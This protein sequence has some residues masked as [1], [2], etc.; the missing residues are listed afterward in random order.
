[1]STQTDVEMNGNGAEEDDTCSGREHVSDLPPNQ[2]ERTGQEE[3]KEVQSR[4]NV[5]L[6]LEQET[7]VQ[8]TIHPSTPVVVSP[9][10]KVSN[11]VQDTNSSDCIQVSKNKE[12]TRQTGSNLS[13]Y[14][15]PFGIASTTSRRRRKTMGETG[16]VE[17]VREI[18]RIYGDNSRR[19]GNSRRQSIRGG[20]GRQNDE[21][22]SVTSRF[23]DAEKDDEAVRSKRQ[24]QQRKVEQKRLNVK[25][26]LADTQRQQDS[27]SSECIDV[28]D[29][30]EPASQPT[31]FDRIRTDKVTNS[32]MQQYL[33]DVVKRCGDD[34]A[35]HE[36]K[37]NAKHQ[38]SRRFRGDNHMKSAMAR[39]ISPSKGGR[40]SNRDRDG[41]LR[42]QNRAYGKRDRDRGRRGVAFCDSDPLDQA[43]SEQEADRT[44]HST[45]S[46]RETVVE[47]VR[48]SQ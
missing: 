27:A 24:K 38:K 33:E 8:R 26:A 25:N 22:G 40:V 35:Y 15:G 4:G 16:N 19:R 31:C 23:S 17:N 46:T 37:D 7:Q 47:D 28:D 21:S 14:F 1:M 34:D 13:N 39:S 32:R 2:Q 12:I 18:D 45:Q 36:Y 30:D 48:Q 10:D 43:R 9:S 3:V 44:R 42:G 6:E 11:C 20:R 5:S 29:D 41:Q